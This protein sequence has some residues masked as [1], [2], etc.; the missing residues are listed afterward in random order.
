MS[1]YPGRGTRADDTPTS[2][3]RVTVRD[4]LTR[5]TPRQRAVLAQSPV[6]GQGEPRCQGVSPVWLSTA[7]NGVR[8]HRGATQ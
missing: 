6:V 3:L 8:H 5:I 4:A 2:G 7:A 1:P